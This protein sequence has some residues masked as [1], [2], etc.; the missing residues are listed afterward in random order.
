MPQG[1]EQGAPGQHQQQQDLRFA[2]DLLS[3]I[4]ELRRDSVVAGLRRT[5]ES[6]REGRRREVSELRRRLGDARQAVEDLSIENEWLHSLCNCGGGDV[7]ESAI[8]ERV[9]NGKNKSDKAHGRG[10]RVAKRAGSTTKAATATATNGKHLSG[11]SAK[12]NKKGMRRNLGGG[13]VGE[14]PR[15]SSSSKF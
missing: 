15:T 10:G 4:G 13:R 2:I 9:N 6:E 3:S 7:P 11:T 12:K 5:L 8:V 1:K 14:T